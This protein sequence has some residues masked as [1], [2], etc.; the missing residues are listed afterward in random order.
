MQDEIRYGG[1]LRVIG[2]L[3]YDTYELSGGR[4]PLRRRPRLPAGHDRRLAVALASR[5]TAPTP[6]ATARPSITETLIS[7]IHPFPAFTILP[8]PTLRPEVAHNVEGGVNLKYN[9]VFSAQGD[10]FRAKVNVFSNEI[11]NFINIQ[12]VGPT[13]FVPAIAGIPASVCA[14]HPGRASPA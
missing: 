14:R 1:W 7:G 12:A 3:R 2:A 8:N 5:S 6:R 10:T 9:D 4:L 13:Y 11:D